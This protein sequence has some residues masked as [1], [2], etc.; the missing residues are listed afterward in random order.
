MAYDNIQLNFDYDFKGEIQ[1]PSAKAAVGDAENGLAP[2]HMLFGALGSCF[3]ATFLAV[4]K[5]MRLTYDDAHLEISGWKTDP[6]LKIIDQVKI[7]MTVTNP[8]DE[9]RLTKA[10]QLGAR[11]CSIHELVSK[12]AHIELNIEFK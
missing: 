2:Y 5:K 11:Y 8:S 6:K 3:Y 1:S 10:A 12:A 7:D 9:D 4:A